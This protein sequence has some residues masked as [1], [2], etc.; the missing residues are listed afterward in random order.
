MR[1]QSHSHRN[2]SKERKAFPRGTDGF[3]PS[4]IVEDWSKAV[5]GQAA[6]DEHNFP[7]FPVADRIGALIGMPGVPDG[8]YQHLKLLL[9]Y[10]ALEHFRGPGVL[11]A[12]ISSS[13]EL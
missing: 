4:A 6:F 10:M 1:R 2:K 13:E 7:T 9:C 11:K 8:I 3:C 5:R 12:G